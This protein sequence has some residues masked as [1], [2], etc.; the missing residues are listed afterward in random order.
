MEIENHFTNSIIEKLVFCLR[1]HEETSK[2][3]IIAC[4]CL[5]LRA[6]TVDENSIIQNIDAAQDFGLVRQ[7]SIAQSIIP[8]IFNSLLENIKKILSSNNNNILTGGLYLLSAV[9]LAAAKELI[10]SLD[11]IKAII[12][13]ILKKNS[14]NF[15]LILFA[16]FNKLLKSVQY[17]SNIIP[18]LDTFISWMVMGIKNDFYKVNIE[19]VQMASQLVRILKETLSDE[20]IIPR[21]KII[22][23]EILPK[24]ISND[25]DQELKNSLITTVGNI[26][27]HTVG[28]LDEATLSKFFDVFLEKF[29]NENLVIICA[30]WIMRI[31]KSDQKIL[32]FNSILKKFIPIIIELINN[33]NTTLRHSAVELLCCIL[34]FYPKAVSGYEKT[35]VL[36]LLDYSSDEGFIQSLFETMLLILNN[37]ELEKDLLLKTINE[38]V[39]VLDSAHCALSEKAA[40][41]LLAYSAS[42][43]SR[44]S[45]GELESL[46]KTLLNFKSLSNSKAK[47]IAYYSKH[48]KNSEKL[49]KTLISDFSSL[50]KETESRKNILLLIGEIALINSGSCAAADIFELISGIFL[51]AND[52]LKAHAALALAKVGLQDPTHFLNVV[53]KLNDKESVRYGLSSVREF[54]HLLCAKENKQLAVKTDNSIISEL[55]NILVSE[56]SSQDEKIMKLCGECVGLL[57]GKS[58]DLLDKYINYLSDSNESI[59][60]GFYYGLKSISFIS[61]EVL[62]MTIFQKLLKGLSDETII[63]KQNAYNSLISF[64]HDYSKIFKVLFNEIWSHFEKDFMIKPEL[65]TEYDIGG[66]MR[67]KSDKGLP[68]RKAIYSTMKILL[69][70]IPEKINFEKALHMLLKGLGNYLFFKF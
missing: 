57:S 38:S 56:I 70:N 44:L 31:L 48:A 26:I 58:V 49:I 23:N 37:F 69:E 52:E 51:T 2:E 9:S 59:R 17:D 54:I 61:D 64:A 41:S 16:F 43:S 50:S 34:Q 6:L 15:N 35:L 28:I 30:N 32:L 1:E 19:S 7:K 24:F 39:K 47:L 18:H 25:L 53:K 12:N 10:L 45:P 65:I 4:L 8:V 55:F 67:I 11:N 21:L 14:S 46:I 66:G 60:A 36:N 33:K 29:K 42:A 27:L 22:N 5:Y 63:V 62:L 68:I 13:E 3:D 40:E 20:E